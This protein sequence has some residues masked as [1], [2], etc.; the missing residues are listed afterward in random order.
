[1][2]KFYKENLKKLGGGGVPSGNQKEAP[3]LLFK[4]YTGPRTK[5][6]QGVSVEGARGANS[7]TR[8]LSLRN[9]RYSSCPLCIS[10]RASQILRFEVG[11]PRRS[12][13]E[14]SKS[15]LLSA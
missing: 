10:E 6:F 7:L 4:T 11:T 1:M 9:G 8:G 15:K 3:T 2:E 13:R 14:D 12:A 5:L